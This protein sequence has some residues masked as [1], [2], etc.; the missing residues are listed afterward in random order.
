VEL[1]ALL[2]VADQ[3]AVDREPA[4]VDLLQVVDAAQE[5]RLARAGGPEQHHH[6]IQTDLKVDALQH[7]QVPEALVHRF[8]LDHRQ[9]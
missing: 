6:L 7:F 4:G 3:L 8:G 9:S 5:R 2:P 1:A